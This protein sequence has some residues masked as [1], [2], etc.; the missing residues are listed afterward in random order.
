[1]TMAEK[2][3][4]HRIGLENHTIKE[5]LTQ[6]RRGQLFGLIVGLAVIASSIIAIISGFPW[7]G[8]ILG[9]GGLTGL[10]SVFVLGRREQKKS[11]ESKDPDKK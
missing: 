6:S 1:M 7:Q 5:Q 3:Q 10:V 11:L 4:D 2:Q 9:T 8:T